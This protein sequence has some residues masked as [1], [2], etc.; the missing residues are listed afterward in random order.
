ML[1]LAC[2]LPGWKSH[3]SLYIYTTAYSATIVL[4]NNNYNI[5]YI[6]YSSLTPRTFSKNDIRIDKLRE[7][8]NLSEIRSSPSLETPHTAGTP[9]Q[10]SLTYLYRL[11]P[12]HP[13]L[14]SMTA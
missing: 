1:R 13:D 2:S 12:I 7:S 8:E 10:F 9:G 4:Y 14:I 5:K 6:V 11:H 3:E